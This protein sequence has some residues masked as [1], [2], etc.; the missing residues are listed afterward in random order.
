M[1]SS[2]ARGFDECIL[3]IAPSEAS[4]RIVVVLRGGVNALSPR[5]A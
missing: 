3:F 2:T 5:R 1:N 4:S